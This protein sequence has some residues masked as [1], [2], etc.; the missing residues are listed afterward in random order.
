MITHHP[1]GCVIQYSNGLLFTAAM[2][3]DAALRGEKAIVA[4]LRRTARLAR[5]VLNG[6]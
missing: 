2:F 6:G 3:H 1:P 4:R 5:R